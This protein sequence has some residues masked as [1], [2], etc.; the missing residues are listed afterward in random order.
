MSKKNRVFL[1][2]MDSVGIGGA[3]DADQYFNGDH[4]DQ[5]SNTVL[6]IIE[7]MRAHGGVKWDNL[8]RLG[9]G[10]A[11]LA[12]TGDCPKELVSQTPLGIGGA[13][14]EYSQGK[15]TPSGHWEIAGAP[16]RWDWHYFPNEIPAFPK[17]L[18]DEILQKTGIEF[19]GNKHASGSLII[20]ELGEEHV[21]TGKPIAY[22]SVDSVFQIAAHENYF[23]LE[24]L[25]RLCEQVAE[26]VHPL[27]LGRVIARPFI[28][29]AGNFIRT[30]NRHDYAIAPPAP[31]IL[32]YAQKQGHT[33]IAIGKIRDIFSGRGI[34]ESYTGLPDDGLF[35]HLVAVAKTA[36]E[37]AL[38]FANFVE[39]DS[40][41]G[42]RRDPL[43]YASHITWFDQRLTEL[44]EAM[45][46]DD[47]LIITA[48]HGNDPTW[49]GTDHT[50]EKVPFLLY[51]KSKKLAIKAAEIGDTDFADIGKTAL[52]YLEIKGGPNGRDV[53]K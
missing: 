16:A 4:S 34:G 45:R 29:E 10:Q 12:S 36:P 46:P 17:A 35:D 38:I 19:I 14:R 51:A 24:R 15:D 8:A 53:L 49:P 33:T 40:A 39:F 32:D 7:F 52:G 47:L 6:H 23:G 26:I 50:R 2:V 31:T 3:P 21:R 18:T 28:G 37:G 13:A 22:T 5:G 48:D 44:L 11:L 41:Y 1:L 25:Y 9:L 20:D 27:K 42:H 30:S 43:G